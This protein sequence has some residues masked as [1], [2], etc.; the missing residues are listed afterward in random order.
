MS[1]FFLC[2]RFLFL[3]TCNGA[4]RQYTD[5]KKD[6][7]MSGKHISIHITKVQNLAQL[8]GATS[9]I[10]HLEKK[11]QSFSRLS[12]VIRLNLPQS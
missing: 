6:A 3:L 8:K 4:K 2:F 5:K 9:R 11:R 1:V 7:R 12:F 10:T